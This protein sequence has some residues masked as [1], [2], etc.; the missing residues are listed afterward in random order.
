MR[1]NCSGE[2]IVI[3]YRVFLCSQYKLNFQLLGPC[4]SR[5]NDITTTVCFLFCFVFFFTIYASFLSKFL[6]IFI[7]YFATLTVP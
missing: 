2:I 3:G 6:H 7:C 4:A 5:N 1:I